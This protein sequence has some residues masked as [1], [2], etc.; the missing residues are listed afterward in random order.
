MTWAALILK[1]LLMNLDLFG[2]KGKKF[3]QFESIGIEKEFRKEKKKKVY[4]R[5]FPLKKV[6]FKR[7]RVK[8]KNTKSKDHRFSD[9]RKLRRMY[10]NC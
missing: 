7:E 9:Q 3:Y 1:L 6:R 10:R 5:K 4:Q 2:L 8:I